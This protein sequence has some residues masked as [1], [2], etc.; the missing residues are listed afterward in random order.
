MQNAL[1]NVYKKFCLPRQTDDRGGPRYVYTRTFNTIVA[2]ILWN[3]PKVHS[4][5][6]SVPYR[7]LDNFR[8]VN[9]IAMRSFE[10]VLL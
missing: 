5:L 9:W 8:C 1:E 3:I 7:N 2:T 4:A 6:D 10:I